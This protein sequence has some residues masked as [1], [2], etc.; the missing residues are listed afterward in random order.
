VTASLS[1]MS[2]IVEVLHRV[3]IKTKSKHGLE[4]E[5]LTQ[6]PLRIVAVAFEERVRL[7]SG[8]KI[9]Q[10]NFSPKDINDREF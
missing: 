7:T 2:A 6:F 4:A 1:S 8:K 9:A 3:V 5:H 10:V